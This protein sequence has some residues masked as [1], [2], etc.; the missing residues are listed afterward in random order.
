MRGALIFLVNKR[1]NALAVAGKGGRQPFLVVVV[2]GVRVEARRHRDSAV[3]LDLIEDWTHHVPSR[4]MRSDQLD[5]TTVVSKS[6]CRRIRNIIWLTSVLGP[7]ED[8]L[9]PSDSLG[10]R[11][12]KL[13]GFLPIRDKKVRQKEQ[14]DQEPWKWLSDHASMLTAMNLLTST[15]GAGLPRAGFRYFPS[16]RLPVDRIS[17]PEG[18]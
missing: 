14:S 15:A 10:A 12:A 7:V 4:E 5:A 3:A 17:H 18:D 11:I 9:F 16:V 2:R 13:A 8:N 6:T 1:V